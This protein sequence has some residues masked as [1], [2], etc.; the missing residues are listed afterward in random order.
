LAC[1]NIGGGGSGHCLDGQAWEGPACCGRRH[2]WLSQLVPLLFCFSSRLQAAALISLYPTLTVTCTLKHSPP[3][4]PDRFWSLFIPAT[5]SKLAQH[6]CAVQKCTW[7]AI[8]TQ[9]RAWSVTLCSVTLCLSPLRKGSPSEAGIR[10]MASELHQA[11]PV[12]LF[13]ICCGRPAAR[14]VN[15]STEM[16]TRAK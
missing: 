12:C 10:L 4:P 2:H 1:D 8:P 9:A 3:L 15:G 16:A 5:E 11:S 7:P 13:P 14:N 6:L